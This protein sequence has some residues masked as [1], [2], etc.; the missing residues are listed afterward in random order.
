MS[1]I[2]VHQVTPDRADLLEA[3]AAVRVETDREIDPDD[4]PV[5]GAE[6]A[7]ELFVPSAVH[8]RLAWVATLD[9]EAA[10][11]LTL[12]TEPGE[13]NRHL[14][15]VES[16]AVRPHLRRRG[17]ADALL[18]AGLGWAV[19]DGRTSFVLWVPALPDGSGVAY[20]TRCGT[21][22]AQEE[23]CSRLR[24]ADL[25]RSLLD[26]W[27]VEGR[28]RSDGY[29]LEQFIGPAPDHLVEAVA[30][31]HRAMEDMPT[32]DLEW[33]IPPMTPEKLRS[34]DDAWAR[35]GW[36]YVSTL[37][38]APDGSAA[39]LSELGINT[40]RPEVASQGDTG[41][42]AEH[43]GR[44]LGRWLKAENLCQAL[45]HEPRIH[46]VQTYNAE[47]NPWMLAINVTMGFRPHIGYRAYQGQISDARRA[48]G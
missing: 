16:L 46:A 42:R 34:R 13:E 41:V 25:D 18:R 26:A 40:H 38:L 32:D 47:T 19:D 5:S 8:E 29:R 33:T 2:E 48:I 31:A 17:V 45:D 12:V 4:Q 6:L 3:V 44:G 9:G 22:L 11:A 24:I 37:A 39:G 15:D 28:S 36:R 43:R 20:A 14:V 35:S 21:T 23:R 30:A 27:I 10:G 7:G 1:T